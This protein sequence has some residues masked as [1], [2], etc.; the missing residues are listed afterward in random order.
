MKVLIRG[1]VLLKTVLA[2]GVLTLGAEKSASVRPGIERRAEQR[3]QE[4]R[5][6]SERLREDSRRR[7]AREQDRLRARDR[8]SLERA[9]WRSSHGGRMPRGFS[10]PGE[11]LRFSETLH[12][13]LRRAQVRDA[14]VFLQGSAVTGRAF[15]RATG[16]W[17]GA[18]FDVG[19]RSD[20]DVAICS[21]SLFARAK[22][23][24]IE[25]RQ[26]RTEPLHSQDLLRRMGL[27]QAAATL[28]R[29]AGRPVRFM[30]FESS[31]AALQRPSLPIPSR[32]N[33]GRP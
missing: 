3:S 20:F 6:R 1:L 4:E 26:S 28:S 10:N 17:T 9:E 13:E 21:Q 22:E 27:D 23:Q 18:K 15:D 25:I 19:R 33:P 30:V 11:F 32:L 16:A 8:E 31:Q 14:E 2:I 5:L 24:G 12:V 7:E 29:Q